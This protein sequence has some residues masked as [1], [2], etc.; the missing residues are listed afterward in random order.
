M[1]RKSLALFLATTGLIAT[2]GGCG[3]GQEGGEKG[4]DTMKSAP[5]G[6]PA[7]APNGSKD[8]DSMEDGSQKDEGGEG[9]E[10]G[11]G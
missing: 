10:G 3:A 2:L 6:Q 5:A 7:P 4:E 1:P 11:E 9:G 8:D